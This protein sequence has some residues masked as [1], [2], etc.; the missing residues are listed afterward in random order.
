[1]LVQTNE[2]KIGVLTGPWATVCGASIS[3]QQTPGR[4]TDELA[5]SFSR[6]YVS[7]PVYAN[8][9]TRD[10]VLQSRN[11]ELIA[12]P[13]WRNTFDGIKHPI[14]IL[15]AGKK[16]VDSA[17]V[18]FIRGTIPYLPFIQLYAIL[19]GRILVQWMAGDLRESLRWYPDAKT[20]RGK[21]RRV[22]AWVDEKWFRLIRKSSCVYMLCSG[23]VLYKKYE[24]RRSTLTVSSTISESEFYYR[25]DTCQNETV[26][27][28]FVG[29]V[30]PGKGLKYLVEALSKLKTRRKVHLAIVG[31]SEGYA[32][33]KRRI[34]KQIERLG[35]QEKVSWEGYAKFGPTLFQQLSQ[36]DLLVLPTLSEGAPHVL[37]EARAFGLPVVSTTVGGIP[38]SVR[39][40]IDGILVP[41]KD[42]HA[43][44]EAID[45][46]IDDAEFRRNLISNGYVAAKN[47][48]FEKFM[49][50]LLNVIAEG[51]AKKRK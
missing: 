6:C 31:D 42:S 21:L 24:S 1:M 28:L 13:G 12:Q 46:I 26:R 10:Y 15:S 22:L 40:G 44:A 11:V 45:T 41:P 3:M 7:L 33:E 25:D 48:S 39:S 43:L 34:E 38:S 2:Y 14:G 27:I 32:K 36:S 8:D 4:I 23:G 29:F 18:I 17:D 30:R 35:L 47:F 20:L 16:I 9:G 37:V 51:L 19:R 5:K 50:Q 49:T